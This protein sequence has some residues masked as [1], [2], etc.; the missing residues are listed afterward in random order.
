MRLHYSSDSGQRKVDADCVGF[1]AFDVLYPACRPVAVP[2]SS[3]VR[4]L[5]CVRTLLKYEYEI[6][7]FV[8][9]VVTMLLHPY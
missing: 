7:S 2:Y 5:R 1:V 8:V 4:T 3:Y 6:M 9:L